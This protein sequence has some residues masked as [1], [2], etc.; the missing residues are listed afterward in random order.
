[1]SKSKVFLSHTH[2][3]QELAT[4]IKDE[5][6]DPHLLGALDI[7]VSSDST[8]NLPGT[9]WLHNIEDSLTMANVILI[10][11]S[12]SSIQKP[13]INIEA[14]AGWIRYL[15]ARDHGGTPVYV[16]P[17]CH[18]GLSPGELPL[19]W[20]TFNAVELRTQGGLHNILDTCARAAGLGRSP[21]PDLSELL[22][23]IRSYALSKMK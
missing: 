4:K 13:W 1:M 19:P 15:Q 18:S 3:E 11:A 8:T 17:L 16:M 2:S 9:S 10:L 22:E 5:L 6:L 14:G 12:P 21:K 7:F 20:S 23:N